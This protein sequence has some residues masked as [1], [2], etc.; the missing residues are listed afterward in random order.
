MPE[1]PT[2]KG[3][4]VKEQIQVKDLA[5]WQ[6]YEDDKVAFGSALKDPREL[7]K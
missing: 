4:V 2:D 3:Y 7:K 1:N 6:P 5:T